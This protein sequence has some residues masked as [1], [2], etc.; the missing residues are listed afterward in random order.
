MT[1]KE[2]EGREMITSLER[3]RAKRRGERR[4]EEKQKN[5]AR[6][7][8]EREKGGI[9]PLRTRHNGTRTIRRWMKGDRGRDRTQR[10]LGLERKRGEKRGGGEGIVKARKGARAPF[11]F[12][13]YSALQSR[14]IFSTR[15][16]TLVSAF[17]SLIN[18][19][20]PGQRCVVNSVLEFI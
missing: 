17:L 10:W 12:T 2:N 19:K 4:S 8:K 13:A 18:N 1:S 5:R 9:P 11:A 3:K 16:E 6:E 15:F 14:W 7:G 20:T